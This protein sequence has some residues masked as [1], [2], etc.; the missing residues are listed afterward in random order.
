ML[1]YCLGCQVHLEPRAGG[2][3]CARRPADALRRGAQP[4]RPKSTEEGRHLFA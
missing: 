2:G 4:C 3:E 1:I